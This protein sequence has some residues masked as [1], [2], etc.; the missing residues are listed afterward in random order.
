MKPKTE[1]V[2]AAVADLPSGKELSSKDLAK[3]I[4]K[5]VRTVDRYRTGEIKKPP[6][7][8]RDTFDHDGEMW[9]KK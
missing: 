7:W 5:T 8:F 3:L 1:E 2:P 4:G 9:V 6:E